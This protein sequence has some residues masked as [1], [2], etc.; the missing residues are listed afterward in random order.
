[1]LLAAAYTKLQYSWLLTASNVAVSD[2]GGQVQPLQLVP[3]T[4]HCK[5]KAH[6]GIT[7][8]NRQ[9]TGR[10]GSIQA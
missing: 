8:G 5:D 4:L 10:L 9:W 3:S 1:M 2:G 7:G 6:E